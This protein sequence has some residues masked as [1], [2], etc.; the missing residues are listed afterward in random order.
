MKRPP[1]SNQAASGG[2]RDLR[3]PGTGRLI[4][5]FDPTRQ[6]LEFRSAG[7]CTRL[8]LTRRT[9]ERHTARGVESVPL[10]DGS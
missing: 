2:F 5:R 3:D 7:E 8:D 9:L 10:D 4:G 6:I 1:S